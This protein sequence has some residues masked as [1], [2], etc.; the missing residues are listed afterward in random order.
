MDECTTVPHSGPVEP[1]LHKFWC[2]LMYA[3]ALHDGA[4]LWHFRKAAEKFVSIALATPS[5]RNMRSLT[6]SKKSSKQTG[7]CGSQWQ[8]FRCPLA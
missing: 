8:P 5:D 7:P 3:I 4:Y 1:I 2:F 6:P